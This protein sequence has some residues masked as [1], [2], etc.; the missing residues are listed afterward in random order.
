VDRARAALAA[1]RAGDALTR[2]D[3]YERNFAEQRFAPEALYLRLEALAV[4]G[5]TDLARKTAE[6]LLA[7]YPNSPQGERA[8]AML[9]KNP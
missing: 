4:L 8:R 5:R 7:R 2:L 6:R 9:S 3:E 1:G